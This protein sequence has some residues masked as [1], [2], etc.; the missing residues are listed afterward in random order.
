MTDYSIDIPKGRARRAG[1]VEYAIYF[2]PV[3]VIALPFSLAVWASYPLR[4][5]RLPDEGPLARA[6]KDARGIVA[7]IIRV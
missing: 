5:G 6:L 1:A 3:F 7:Q 4:K 2:A